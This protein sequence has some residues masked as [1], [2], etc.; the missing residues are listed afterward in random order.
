[1]APTKSRRPASR[2]TGADGVASG[3]GSG[4]GS[5]TQAHASG[6][7]SAAG[8]F[9]AHSEGPR[10]LLERGSARVPAFADAPGGTGWQPG[11]EEEAAAAA[12]EDAEWGEW[13][14]E[15]HEHVVLLDLGPA[16]EKLVKSSAEYSISGLETDTP[17]LTIGTSMFAGAWDEA[18]G[19]EILLYDTHSSPH[20][21]SHALLPLAPT[22]SDAAF[23]RAPSTS[24]ARI[25]FLPLAPPAPPNNKG[26]KERKPRGRPKLTLEERA[27]RALA[28]VMQGDVPKRLQKEEREQRAREKLERKAAAQARKEQDEL[29]SQSESGS[30]ESGSSES[31][32][33]D[34]DGSDGSDEEGDAARE[35]EAAE[36][37]RESEQ[38]TE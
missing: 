33:E 5:H 4:S 25:R 28:R 23:S 36:R 7:S 38:E 19:S 29:T 2:R 15:E 30:D 13:E 10:R 1:M 24:A 14:Y 21:T 16:V 3:S 18:L 27:Q 37:E 22:P 8:A 11:E 31:E 20:P 17:F 32:S 6:S 26:A 34:S 12:D 35:K 9:D